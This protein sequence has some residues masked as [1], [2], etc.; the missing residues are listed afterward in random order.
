MGIKRASGKCE[1]CKQFFPTLFLCRKTAKSKWRKVCGHCCD[2][3][4]VNESYK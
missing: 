1:D 2:L 4:H 3:T